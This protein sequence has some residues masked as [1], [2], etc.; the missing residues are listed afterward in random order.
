M[1]LAHT[2]P[3]GSQ[4]M[5][6]AYDDQVR[7]VSPMGPIEKLGGGA[8]GVQKDYYTR[9]GTEL[10]AGV[11]SGLNALSATTAT[12][13]VLIVIGDGNDTNN[14]TAPAE[15]AA[16]K[17]FAAREHIH[18]LALIYK[19]QLSADTDVIHS[20]VSGAQTVTTH[21]GIVGGLTA[22][23]AQLG[24]RYTVRFPGDE[25]RWDGRSQDF[26]V[27]LGSDKLEPVTLYMSEYAG[28]SS[29]SV[30]GA[31]WKQLAIGLGI[32]ATIALLMRLR[33]GRASL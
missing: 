32:V 21:E 33:A 10:V 24:N 18:T 25:L 1:D 29:C 23:V 17:R 9:V 30:L 26:T 14:E 28:E 4:G 27:Q 6:L 3:R 13:K 31:W 5:L 12:H 2:M 16:L 7:T 19:S 20:L 22:I 8:I 11:R 15:L